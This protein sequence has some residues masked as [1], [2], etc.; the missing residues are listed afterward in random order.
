MQSFTSDHNKKATITSWNSEEEKEDAFLKHSNCCQ[1]T[2]PCN[3]QVSKKVSK[4]SILHSY[5]Y[6][7]PWISL[8][9][10]GLYVDK[11]DKDIIPKTK[12][13]QRIKQWALTDLYS[14]SKQKKQLI[15]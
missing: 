10:V 13:W 15:G 8:E 11:N 3:T 2:L 6:A 12:Y 4:C 9:L 7:H 14:S 1:V 5:I